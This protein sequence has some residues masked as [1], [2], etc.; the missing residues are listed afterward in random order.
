MLTPI[1]A[2][3]RFTATAWMVVALLWPVALLNYLDRQLVATMKAS[4]MADLTDIQTE[5]NFGL[6]MAVFMWVYA[7]LSPVG[8]YLADRFNRRHT[9]IASLGVW[10]L[11]TFLTGHTHSFGEMLWA[12]AFMGVSE[13]CYIPA[14]LALITDFHS[15]NTRSRAVGLH[16]TGIYA[17][18]A[19]GFVGGYIADSHFGWRAAF[20]WFGLAGILYSGVLLL[21]L[22]RLPAPI[23]ESATSRA[24]GTRLSIPAAIAGLFG[25]GSFFLLILHF[26]LPSLSGW[27]IR[28]WMPTYL[29][30]I[31]HLNQGSAGFN[32]TFWYTSFSLVGA[33]VGGT[34][35]DRWMRSTPRGRIFVSA[36]GV[37]LFIPALFALGYAP[38]LAV[39]VA[40]LILFGVG[41]GFYDTNHMPILCQIVRPELRATGFGFLNLVSISAGAGITW[42][43]GA[44]RDAHVPILFPCLVTAAAAAVSIA[45]VLSIRPRNITETRSS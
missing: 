36:M 37:A 43:L 35:A 8:G 42:W 4:I 16:Q 1:A 27:M 26:T 7:A 32:A 5:K 6:L 3:P 14:A 31:F 41:W 2:P 10:S 11:V 38:T 30:E 12:R 21:G 24:P 33:L 13:A 19:L 25:V 15:G 23:G 34:L 39:A 28:N 29:A 17:G 18:Q 45:L 22:G 20:S 9:V 44:L 40:G